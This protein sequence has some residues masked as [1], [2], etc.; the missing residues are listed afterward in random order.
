MNI[1]NHRCVRCN[2]T[3]S[4]DARC[5]QKEIN[6]WAWY[7]VN[8]EVAAK[9]EVRMLR[10]RLDRE[11]LQAEREQTMSGCLPTMPFLPERWY[12]DNARLMTLEK[13]ERVSAH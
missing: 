11:F 13:L 5:E 4:H 8:Q 6:N 3:D 12:R 2:R 7:M 10:A 1:E 9:E